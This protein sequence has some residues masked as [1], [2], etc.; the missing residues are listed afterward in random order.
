MIDFMEGLVLHCEQLGV[1]HIQWLNIITNIIF[2]LFATLFFASIK[3]HNH[4]KNRDKVMIFSLVVLGI[5]SF[6]WHAFPAAW[7]NYLD[8]GS[9]ILFA[10]IMIALIANKITQNLPLKIFTIIIILIVG[11]YLKQIP[12]LNNSLAYLYLTFIVFM[13]AFGFPVINDNKA[14]VYF[15]RAFVLYVLGF[16]AHKADLAIC[17]FLVTGSHFMWHIFIAWMGYYFAKGIHVLY[18]G[19]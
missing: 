15:R 8:I 5:G 3:K 14:R 7:S 11:I 12:V 17:D 16:I 4:T 1:S 13:I 18:D 6:F 2:F 9:V 10:S 19:E